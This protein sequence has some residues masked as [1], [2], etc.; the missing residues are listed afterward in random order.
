MGLISGIVVFVVVWWV[1]IFAVLP[2]GVRSLHEDEA[3]REAIET[4]GHEPG[5]PVRTDLVKKALL[6]TAITIVIWLIIFGI[7]ESDLLSFRDMAEDLP[8]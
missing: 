2:I 5:A 4:E 8:R 1:V 6:T 3:N 7:V